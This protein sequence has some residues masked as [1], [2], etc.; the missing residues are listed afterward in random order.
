MEQKSLRDIFS[1]TY[2]K[3]DYE[4]KTGEERT[5]ILRKALE[6]NPDLVTY[7]SSSRFKN[8][9]IH[10]NQKSP[11]T[12]SEYIG[13]N[14]EKLA[15]YILMC[16]NELELNDTSKYPY[17]TRSD[18]SRF[19]KREEVMSEDEL[20]YFKELEQ[21]AKRKNFKLDNKIKVANKDRLN[22]PYL[23]ETT[24]SL[25][26]LKQI[27]RQK[28]NNLSKEEQLCD[29]EIKKIKH[30]IIEIGKDEV[31]IKR[32]MDGIIYFKRLIP[33]TTVYSFDSDTGYVNEYGQ[34]KKI[35]ENCVK[36]ENK[37]HVES[38]LKH[39]ATLK[40]AVEYDIDSDIKHIIWVLDDFIKKC[41]F[42][43]YMLYIIKC[44][45]DGISNKNVAQL[46]NS[47]Y[48]KKLTGRDVSRAL[49]TMA[50][51]IKN[52]FLK[53]KKEW[54]L[55]KNKNTKYK[56]CSKCGKTKPLTRDF[57]SLNKISRDGYYSI[58]KVCK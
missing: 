10:K 48:N 58:C 50:N 26:A 38:L 47:K 22:N 4:V 17:M 13:K 16:D 35:T 7:L 43:E 40:N 25:K 28:C 52:E 37:K 19:K 32:I 46:V 36:F 5:E 9:T 57:F 15:D 23:T 39:Y 54:L 51:K 49:S 53:N 3:L 45:A 1:N 21:K 56:R 29:K 6:D 33:D 44:K 55:S 24:I 42:D 34:Y 27:L 11:Q 14:L 2:S 12:E 8:K 18:F 20:K 41:D 30:T 31:E